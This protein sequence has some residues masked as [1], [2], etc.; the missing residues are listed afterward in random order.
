MFTAD[1]SLGHH[2]WDIV[3]LRGGN[4]TEIVLLSSHFFCLTT[5]W[6]KVTL[7]CCGDDCRLCD[8]LP[9]RGLFYVAVGCNGRLSILELAAQSSSYFEQHAK[10]FHGGMIP[11]LVFQLSRR[12]D[13]QPI[14]SEVVRF[15]D[16]CAEVCHLTL[17]AHVMALYKFP[18]PNPGE[19]LAAYEGRC[20][21]I[22]KVRCDR[23]ADLLCDAS[24]RQAKV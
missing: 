6:N 11:G 24:K 7:P 14:I 2:R 22:A 19:D 3:R 23:A 10:L 21:L 20:R 4:R 1:S 18:C 17:A 13:K 5:H 16:K 15:Q 8:L 9:A 12:G